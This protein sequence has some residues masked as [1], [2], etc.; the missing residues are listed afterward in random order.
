MNPNYDFD[1]LFKAISQTLEP[2]EKIANSIREQRESQL[3]KLREAM[4]NLASLQ[5]IIKSF[6]A[7]YSLLSLVKD[8]LIDTL[9]LIE[10]EDIK[11]CVL[12]YQG[13][14]NDS[15]ACGWAFRELIKEHQPQVKTDKAIIY[16]YEGTFTLDKPLSNYLGTNKAFK[17]EDSFLYV[18]IDNSIAEEAREL[19]NIKHSVAFDNHTKHICAKTD[20]ENLMIRQGLGNRN[21]LSAT[22]ELVPFLELTEAEKIIAFSADSV[23]TSWVDNEFFE[24]KQK[25]LKSLQLTPDSR[26][27]INTKKAFFFNY[28]TEKIEL[29][30]ELIATYGEADKAMIIETLSSMLPQG[31][32]KIA[33]KNQL[34][35][36][37][38]KIVC[39]QALTLEGALNEVEYKAFMEAKTV[40]RED[41]IIYNDNLYFGKAHYINYLIKTN[42]NFNF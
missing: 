28:E 8:K 25:Q 35:S 6:E 10:Q 41:I 38:A 33:K 21:T 39:Q 13:L 7:N 40:N 29:K 17:G 32:F 34:F 18:F 26:N 30:P 22:V 16:L 12:V 37:P 1:K 27:Y 4:R 42:W 31:H 3:D 19:L 20:I 36:V 14:D 5:D 2:L 24:A 9:E 15:V 23:S 11:E